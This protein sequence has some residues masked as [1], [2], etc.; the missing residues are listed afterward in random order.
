MRADAE[1]T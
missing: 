1:M